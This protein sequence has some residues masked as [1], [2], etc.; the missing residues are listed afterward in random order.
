M[1]L[2]YEFKM[3]LIDKEFIPGKV[4][5]LKGI[6]RQTSVMYSHFKHRALDIMGGS[7]SLIY[8]LL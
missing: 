6:P 4:C 2:H 7:I 1:K 8:L 3:T 5:K